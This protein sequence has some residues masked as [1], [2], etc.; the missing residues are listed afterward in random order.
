MKAARF[1]GTRDIRVENV[2][3]PPLKSNEVG[4]EI[5]WC[6]ICGSD[7]HTY[8]RPMFSGLKVP[9]IM[10]HEFSGIVKEIGADVKTIKVGDRVVVNPLFVCH[11]CYACTHGHPN[12]CQNIVLYGCGPALDGAYAEYTQVPEYT[13]V[14]IPD[15]LPLDKAAVVEPAG[16]AFHSLRISQFKAGDDAA[17]FG[18]GPIGLLMISELKAAGANRIYS[19]AH[20]EAR[21]E[22]AKRFGATTVLDPDKDDVVK[23]IREQTGVGVSVS[24]DFAGADQTLAMGLAVL[25]AKGELIMAA[26]PAKPLALNV[27]A[28]IR[29]E[30]T[31]KASQCTNDEFPMVAQMIADGKIF[32]DDV[33]TK[34]IYID[35]IAKEGFEALTADKSQLKILVTAHKQYL[36]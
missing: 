4:I 17:V 27:F 36:R 11:D 24:Y 14:K 16:I 12:L 18:A 26:L 22:Q 29:G 21:R 3:L 25:H 10:G 19:V 6:G 30:Q 5:A 13:A 28:L 1:Y 8:E 31:M 33:I 20:S 7:K 23:I 34:K 2:T 9:F 35:D 15:N 32:V